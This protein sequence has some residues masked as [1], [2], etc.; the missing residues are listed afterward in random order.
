MLNEVIWILLQLSIDKGSFALHVQCRVNFK[1]HWSNSKGLVS[2]FQGFSGLIHCT[3]MIPGVKLC[4]AIIGCSWV[5]HIPLPW[6]M[7]CRQLRPLIRS[8]HDCPNCTWFAISLLVCQT[9]NTV[10]SKKGSDRMNASI[11][12][13]L[14]KVRFMF[15]TSKGLMNSCMECVG[16]STS[17]KDK[18]HCFRAWRG[19]CRVCRWLL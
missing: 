16:L 7:Y 14:E 18:N 19:S 12:S 13:E 15:P 11:C 9:L 6:Y 8:A 3:H 4:L 10:S 17:N 5:H 1:C 2:Q